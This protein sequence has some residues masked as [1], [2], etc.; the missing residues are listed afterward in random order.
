VPDKGVVL[1]QLLEDLNITHEQVAY[2]G[3]DLPDLPILSAVGLAICPADAVEAVKAQCHWVTTAVGGN[4]A[5]REAIELL[6]QA[7]QTKHPEDITIAQ[8]K[9]HYL[10]S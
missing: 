8:A 1:Q 5:M 10:L 2:M 9:K 3:D 7:K 4:A 6:I